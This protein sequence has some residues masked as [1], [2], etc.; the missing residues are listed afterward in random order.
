MSLNFAERV[1][2]MKLAPDHKHFA[3]VL[4]IQQSIASSLLTVTARVNAGN[5]RPTND[6]GLAALLAEIN[7]SESVVTAADVLN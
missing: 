5:L 3:R 7:R 6:D 2:K 4:G 1:M